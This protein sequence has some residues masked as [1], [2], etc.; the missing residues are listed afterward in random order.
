[1]HLGWWFIWVLL[2]VWI[3]VTPYDI[4]G[5]RIIKDAPIDILKRSFASGEISQEQFLEQKNLLQ[6]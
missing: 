4:P 6:K 5:Q 2:L 1:M 3:F